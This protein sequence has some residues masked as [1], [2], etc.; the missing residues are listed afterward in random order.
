MD[1]PLG[2]KVRS[3]KTTARHEVA[4][5]SAGLNIIFVTSG[6]VT[7]NSLNIFSKR[8]VT[9]KEKTDRHIN[10]N[11]PTMVPR[12]SERDI[13][14]L[15]VNRTAYANPSLPLCFLAELKLIHSYTLNQ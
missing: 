9:K 1:L 4:M 15:S 6:R 10:N 7:S 13:E 11:G 8:P 12:G 3:N 2:V 5:G 14:T